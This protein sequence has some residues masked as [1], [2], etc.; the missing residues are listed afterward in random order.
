[1]ELDRVHAF[2]ETCG[3]VE[4]EAASKGRDAH[5]DPK[6]REYPS[7]PEGRTHCFLL[8]S[9]HTWKANHCS[10]YCMPITSIVL[11]KVLQLHKFMI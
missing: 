10:C 2:A 1:M 9:G 7:F 3:F 5:C 6:Q 4:V 11:L 8:S